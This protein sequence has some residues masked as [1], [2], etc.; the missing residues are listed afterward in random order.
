[1]ARIAVGV[2]SA[3][4]HQAAMAEKL[5]ADVDAAASA[6]RRLPKGTIEDSINRMS[7]YAREMNKRKQR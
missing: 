4:P 2:D 6:A 3:L 1:V 7:T 5:L